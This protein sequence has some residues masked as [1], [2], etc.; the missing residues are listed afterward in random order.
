M[1]DSSESMAFDKRGIYVGITLE[2]FR[3]SDIMKMQAIPREL[4]G[5]A[6]RTRSAAIA[7][8]F[9]QNGGAGPVMTNDG[10]A[11]FHASHGN[12][13]TGAFSSAEWKAA[14]KR[15]FSQLVPGRGSK[16]SLWPTYCLVPI[17]A[18]DDALEIFGYGTGDVGRPNAGGTA[19]IVNPYAEGRPGDPRPIPIPV[20]EWGD[21]NDWAYIVDPRLH[22]VVCMAFA[23]APQGGVHVLPEILRGARRDVRPDVRQRHAAHKNPRLVDIWRRHACGGGE[24]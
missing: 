20:P 7:S 12:L 17:D 4:M 15:I 22:P 10:L 14:R 23:N 21:S 9:T 18:Y 1:D 8:I 19:Q 6:I 5:A 16:L 24:E 13:G 2:M 3:R 11:L